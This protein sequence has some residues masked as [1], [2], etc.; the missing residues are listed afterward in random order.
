MLFSM[1]S[2]LSSKPKKDLELEPPK[3]EPEVTINEELVSRSET[4]LSEP[5][6]STSPM[7]KPEE[8]RKRS[9]S[10]GDDP[11]EDEDEPVRKSAKRNNSTSSTAESSS[12]DLSGKDE[13]EEEDDD[14][15]E[16][17]VPPT[18]M[19]GHRKSSH[20]KPPYSYIAL[21]AMSILNSPEKKLTLSEICDF[22]MN[23]FDYYKEKFPAWQNSIRH[24]LSLN[25]CF[26]KVPRGPGNPGKGN[27]WTLDPKCEDMFDNGSFLR[28]RKRYKKTSE[29][30]PDMMAHHP[31]PFPPFLPQGMFVPPRMM[32]P[33]AA[34]PMMGPPHPMNPRNVPAFFL[35]PSP[36]DSQKLLSYMASRVM[37]M[38]PIVST[39]PKRSSSSSSSPNENGSSPRSE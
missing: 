37:P 1:E 26:V 5:S 4:R 24:N 16:I 6:T 15:E 17:S 31:M 23:R 33:M 27:Y 34:M 9:R 32:H 25:D 36:L 10:L 21:I 3:L 2:I 7:D 35:P 22:I 14:D 30:F 38:D 12:D 18:S 20:S 11:T 8:T 19:S 39:G 29:D 13:K 28:R